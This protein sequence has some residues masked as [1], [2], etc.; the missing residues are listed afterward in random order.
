[1]S[2]INEL[3]LKWKELAEDEFVSSELVKME[4]DLQEQEESFYK[5][6]AFGTGG[7]RGVIGAG[8]NR[9]NRY[10]ITKATMGLAKYLLDQ[11]GENAKDSGVAIAY[12]SRRFSYE[13]AKISALVL[14]HCGIKSYLFKNLTPTPMASF[15]VNYLNCKAG[16]V[17]TAS[18]NPKKYNGY[19][20]YNDEGCQI[21]DDAATAISRYID[22]SDPFENITVD[23][24]NNLFNVIDKEVNDAFTDS[25]L[26]HSLNK[27]EKSKQA[28][29]VVFTPI[30][31]SGNIPVRTV[32]EKAGFKVDL[33]EEQ[34][35]PNGEFPTVPFP[36][37]EDR[38][39]LLL[40]IEKAE[41]IGANIAFG[42]DPDCDRIGVAV[43]Y[44]DKF[45]LLTGNQLGALLVDYILNKKSSE[46][47]IPPNSAVVKTI[48]TNE[49]GATI[50]KS[51]GLS[52]IDT[53]TGFKYIGEKII[54]FS[55][56]NE[57]T[58][59]FGYE[60]SFGYLIGT[61]AK[62]KDAVGAA[63]I[64]CEMTAEY[65]SQNITLIDKLNMLYAEYG[66]YL[67]V[68]DSVTLEGQ[69][70]MIKINQMM[71]DIRE[72]K[73]DFFDGTVKVEDYK[74]GIN[75]L[76]KSNVIKFFLNDGSWVAV[77]PSGTEPKIKVYY[78]VK[79]KD[80]KSATV[81]LEDL[82]STIQEVVK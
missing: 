34:V 46:N 33:V 80:E 9:I 8:S 61:Y 48:V 25:V 6:L 10:T 11:Y 49:L 67:D 71:I 14:N 36:N 75:G 44:D 30:H 7:L 40:A 5:E 79:S 38:R 51:K 39:A 26:A 4:N 55:K 17:I 32:L 81:R 63:L 20:V 15:A 59:L 47:S 62:D 22:I 18:H 19:K 65:K 69:E 78:S 60:E 66:Y 58:Y 82:K 37:P 68:L 42:T 52:I 1:M 27:D 53:L 2:K 45:V 41:K 35:E 29:K 28:V 50:A 73:D 31:G 76:P 54:E 23:E 57:Y 77:R 24:N 56:S 72:R 64:L 16:I 21:T 74:D 12:D 3:F 70:G 43:K 13:F